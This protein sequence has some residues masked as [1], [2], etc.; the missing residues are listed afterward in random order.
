VEKIVLNKYKKYNMIMKSLS[1]K[2]TT[3]N[4]LISVIFRTDLAYDDKGI[5]C[6]SP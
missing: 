6:E 5:G 3:F 1:R 4:I 2:M